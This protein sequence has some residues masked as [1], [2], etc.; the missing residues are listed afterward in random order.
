MGGTPSILSAWFHAHVEMAC[1]CA[2]RALSEGIVGDCVLVIPVGN[3]N[4]LRCRAVLRC[5]CVSPSGGM[6]G[7]F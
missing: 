7:G 3:N 4:D 1:L 6:N 2:N 5:H